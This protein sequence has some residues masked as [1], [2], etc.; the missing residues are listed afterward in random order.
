MADI[1]FSSFSAALAAHEHPTNFSVYDNDLQFQQDADSIVFLT[2][3]SVGSPV[4]ESELAL[5]SIWSSFEEAAMEYSQTIN[6]H[7]ARNILIDLLGL[8]SGTLSG[9]ENSLPQANNTAFS[10]RLTLQYAYEAQLNSPYPTH[11]GSI[12][13]R[14]GT[15]RYD[16]MSIITGSH[17]SFVKGNIQIRKIHHYEPTAAY[18]FFDTTSVLNFLGNG[19]NFASYSPETIF[20][21][22][23]IF[24]DVLRG[25]QLEFNQRVRRSNYSFEIQGFNIRVFPTPTRDLKVY[26][27]YTATPDS[28]DESIFGSGTVR[29]VTSNLSN[30]AFGFLNYSSINSVGKNW[31]YRM[32]VALAK[33]KLANIRGLYS[34]IPIPNGEVTLNWQQLEGQAQREMEN[35]RQELK[36]TL[37]SLTY[38][39]LMQER[40]DLQDLAV[41]EWNRLP[42]FIYR[43]R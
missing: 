28:G 38:K 37:E 16:L 26:F 39:S 21:M 19:M 42:K 36:E 22:L 3:R 31:I 23:P 43:S 17:P 40:S 1:T 29:G 5:Y 32:T 18:R 27:E 13:L 15:Q 14:A 6:Q 30:A 35:L 25:E 12:Q 11:T 34:S 33:Q 8:T 9:S 10:R 2:Q 20:Y 41:K 7:H 24:E 4:L